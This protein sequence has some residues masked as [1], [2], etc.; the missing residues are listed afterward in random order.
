MPLGRWYRIDVMLLDSE[1]AAVQ[2]FWA[3]IHSHDELPKTYETFAGNGPA[4]EVQSEMPASAGITDIGACPRRAV[5][6]FTRPPLGLSYFP[7]HRPSHTRPC[8]ASPPGE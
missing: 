2:S 7:G 6:G 5:D 3:R 1:D 4:G 8:G